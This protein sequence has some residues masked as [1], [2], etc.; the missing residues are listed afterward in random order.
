MD[1]IFSREWFLRFLDSVHY[2]SFLLTGGMNLGE[3]G[4][5]LPGHLITHYMCSSNVRGGISS[6]Y[7]PWD[8]VGAF[9]L[10]QLYYSF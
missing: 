10:C 3:D 5:P 4:T 6:S 2:H 8:K 9:I 7:N 1:F